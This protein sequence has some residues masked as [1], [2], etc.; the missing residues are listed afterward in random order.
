MNEM[1]SGACVVSTPDFRELVKRMREAQKR[2]FRTRSASSL[3]EAKACEKLV[4]EA[5]REDV[6]GGLF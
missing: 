3:D 5:L 6:Q 2:Y 1:Q 4:D